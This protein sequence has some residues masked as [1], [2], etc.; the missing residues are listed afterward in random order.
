MKPFSWSLSNAQRSKSRGWAAPSLGLSRQ[1]LNH[2]PKWFLTAGAD[3]PQVVACG[4]I[5][6]R[7]YEQPS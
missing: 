7:Q 1:R 6:M 3:S 2:E 5:P 4:K